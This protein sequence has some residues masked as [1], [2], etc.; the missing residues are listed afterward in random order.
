MAL[1]FG[2]NAIASNVGHIEHLHHIRLPLVSSDP[3]AVGEIT[4]TVAN[5]IYARGVAEFANFSRLPLELQDKVWRATFEPRTVRAIGYSGLPPPAPLSLL[6]E[7]D[8]LHVKYLPAFSVCRRS[9]AVALATYGP[10]LD[11]NTTS[12]HPDLDTIEVVWLRGMTPDCPSFVS[13]YASMRNGVESLIM[14]TGFWRMLR[15]GS[16]SGT[17][18]GPIYMREKEIDGRVYLEER[19]EGDE[20]DTE[21]ADDDQVHYP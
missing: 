6:L 1:N 5:K 12:F 14:P 15:Y 7:S 8:P 16:A 11:D 9:R 13:R 21:G 3:E 2:H 4:D 19:P 20:I 18:D 17:G 10:I